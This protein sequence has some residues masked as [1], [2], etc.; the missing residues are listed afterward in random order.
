[1]P[2]LKSHGDESI[3]RRGFVVLTA[4]S[5]VTA[6]GSNR[7]HSYGRRARDSRLRLA[8][9]SPATRGHPSDLTPLL[10]TRPNVSPEGPFHTGDA[11]LCKSSR[12]PPVFCPTSW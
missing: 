4:I 7:R 1:M 6:S 10:T 9:R 11:P 2:S 3:W 5:P 12:R 8:L